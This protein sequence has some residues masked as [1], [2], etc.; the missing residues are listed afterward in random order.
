MKPKLV[1]IVLTFALLA[2]CSQKSPSSN[3]APSGT[4]SGDYGPSADN[5][6]P[7]T[8]DLRWE[9]TSLR[10]TVHAGP[11]SLEIS[12][13][14]FKPDTGAISIE[15]DAQANGRNVHYS[16][17]GKVEGNRMTGTWSRDGQQGDFRVT[18]Q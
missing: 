13:A 4:W 17:D 2:A 5:R 6:D 14:S 3:A 10:G 16:V 1:Y 18:K 9:D 11:R 8:L 7:V 15:F 12:K